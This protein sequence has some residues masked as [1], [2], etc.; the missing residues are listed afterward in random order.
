MLIVATVLLE[1]LHVPPLAASLSVVV[2]PRQTC[3]LPY[4]VDTGFTFMV[5]LAVVISPHASVAVTVYTVVAEGLT[6][7]GEPVTLP[8]VHV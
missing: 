3:G 7:T 6:L 2:L 8:G 4:M 5:V 1:L